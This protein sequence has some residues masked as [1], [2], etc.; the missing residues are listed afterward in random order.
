MK[1]V[2][3]EKPT[4]F[5]DQVYFGCTQRECK[6]NRILVDEYRKMFKS[7]ISEGATENMP[8]SGKGNGTVI[9][10]SYDMA[11]HA[12]KCVERCC[13]LA[14]KHIEQLYKVSTLCIDDN[15]NR[16]RW[17]NFQKHAL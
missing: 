14:N 5:L 8:D 13:E 11:G 9:A 17:E 15:K 10:W 12:H 4:S 3:L 7:R 1:H 16:K 2:A 6:P